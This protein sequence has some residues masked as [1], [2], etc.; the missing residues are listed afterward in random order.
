MI[1]I[2]CNETVV[3]TQRRGVD[4]IYL[5]SISIAEHIAAHNVDEVGLRI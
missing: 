2:L 1:K 3:K 5:F 4:I